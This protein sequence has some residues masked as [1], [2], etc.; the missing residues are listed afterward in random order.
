MSILDRP[1]DLTPALA[2]VSR[3]GFRPTGVMEGVTGLLVGIH[4]NAV[5]SP[6]S[7]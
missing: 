1:F 6:P 2:V 3:S 7:A 5:P 4:L